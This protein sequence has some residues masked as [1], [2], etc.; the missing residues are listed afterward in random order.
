MLGGVGREVQIIVWI[1]GL[2]HFQ[3]YILLN[4]ETFKL[5]ESS[6]GYWKKDILVCPKKFA[7]CGL[8]FLILRGGIVNG[9]KYQSFK[10]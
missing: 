4:F 5:S 6:Y 7:N 1:H 8:L 2:L 3:I 10:M 9:K